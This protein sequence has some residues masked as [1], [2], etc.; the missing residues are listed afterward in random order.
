MVHNKR[1]AVG[2]LLCGMALSAGALGADKGADAKSMKALIE[3]GKY[4]VTLG[5]C[6]HCHS[7]KVF[8]PMGPV[9]DTT[10]LLSGHPASAAPLNVPK[11]LI[12]PDKWGALTNNDLTEWAGPWGVSFARNLTPDPATGIGSWTEDIFI[13]ALRTGKDMGKGRNI[14]PP[15][16]W[17]DIGQ[18]TDGDLKAMFAYLKS[19]KPIANA[20]PNPISPTGEGIPPT[21][22]PGKK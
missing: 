10:R 14:L 19:L 22:E 17:S 15:M 16:P 1:F 12:A 5:G 18:L 7:P 2:V 21:I 9:P 11:D 20:V 6:N 4:L 8:T 3:R 13:A